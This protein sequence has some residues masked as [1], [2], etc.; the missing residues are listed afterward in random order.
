MGVISG[1][2]R[3]ETRKSLTVGTIAGIKAVLPE[4]RELPC[5][6]TMHQTFPSRAERRNRLWELYRG[7][8]FRHTELQGHVYYST[9]LLLIS[10]LDVFDE[11]CRSKG[12][13]QKQ[14]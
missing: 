1:N 7:R 14:L 12:C 5:I 2:M 9:I 6:Y 13:V 8:Y 10:E 4:Y 11:G 3:D